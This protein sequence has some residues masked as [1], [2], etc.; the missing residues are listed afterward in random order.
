M[1]EAAL[2]MNLAILFFAIAVLSVMAV[3][4]LFTLVGAVSFVPYVPSGRSKSRIMLDLASIG[5]GARIAE[6]GSGDGL[7]CL[8]AAKRGATSLGIEINPVLVGISKIRARF[9]KVDR[10]CSFVFADMWKFKLPPET[11]AVFVYGWPDFMEKLWEKLQG[12][13]PAGTRIVSHAFMFPG[14]EPERSSG[15]VRLYRLG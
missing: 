15:N 5:E 4:G 7:L 9:W 13:L 14:R 2:A 10:R 11:D 6:I 3:Y 8:M 12:E 1:S